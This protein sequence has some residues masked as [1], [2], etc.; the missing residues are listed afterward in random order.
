MPKSTS[1]KVREVT[2]K[3][4]KD[5]ERLFQTKGGPSYCWCM[6]WR[7]TAAEDKDADGPGR[8]KMMAKR[9]KGGVPVGLLAYQGADP[10]AWC[11]VAPKST[12]R[13]LGGPEDKAAKEGKVYSLTCF[14]VKREF[15]RS[16]VMAK[17]IRAAAALA[18]KKGAEVLEAYPVDPDSPSY[19]FMGYVSVFKDEGFKELGMAGTRRHVM[20]LELSKER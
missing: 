5:F 20:R 15:R 16:G 19:R 18:R 9:V 14:F 8:K 4:W 7:R 11:S 17:L 1:W 6:V 2:D 3:T 13:G 12:F 10:V